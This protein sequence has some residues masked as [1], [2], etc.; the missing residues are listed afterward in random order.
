MA[1]PSRTLVAGF[2]QSPVASRSG[3][4]AIASR[5]CGDC[6]PGWVPGRSRGHP[7]LLATHEQCPDLLTNPM[8]PGRDGRRAEP[9]LVCDLAVGLS[10]QHGPFEDVARLLRELHERVQ[11]VV[12]RERQPPGLWLVFRG[13]DRPVV[14]LPTGRVEPPRLPVP[15]DAQVVHDGNQPSHPVATEPETSRRPERRVRKSREPGRRRLRG[16]GFSARPSA[17]GRRDGADRTSFR[18]RCGSGSNWSSCGSLPSRP[19]PAISPANI[20][21]PISRAPAQAS[22]ASVR[23]WA[24][25]SGNPM[26]VVDPSSAMA[27]SSVAGGRSQPIGTLSTQVAVHGAPG[28][29]EQRS[30][31]VRPGGADLGRL[32]VAHHQAQRWAR[33]GHLAARDQGSWPLERRLGSRR[34]VIPPPPGPPGRLA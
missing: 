27:R 9:G 21:A 17:T 12:Q 15:V 13:G 18:K 25:S 8:Q 24:V 20:C 10:L 16:Y 33:A 6:W 1:V 11:D 4:P 31:R 14:R 26:G 34:R 28:L 22:L 32:P 7:L 30:D 3:Q 23:R 5:A 19:S 29:A 2:V